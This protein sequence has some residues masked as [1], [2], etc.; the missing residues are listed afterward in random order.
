MH[1]ILG[2]FSL[3]MFA[4]IWWYRMKYLSEAAGEA[5]DAIGRVQSKIRREKMRKKSALAP[6][7]AID[8]PITA[9][10]TIMASIASEDS[11]LSPILE[12]GVR[13]Q[14]EKLETGGKLEEA[15]VYAKWASEQVAN[16]PSVI[17]VAGK[18]LSTKLNDDEKH[19]LIDMVMNAVPADKRHEA[20]P[21]RLKRL[22]VKLG[23]QVN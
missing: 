6:I 7:T 17:D 1:I 3:I 8:D 16:V 12:S 10:A 21:D 9:A 19:E 2:L 4:A 13:A 20:F 18:Y 23:L 11:V 15:L 22:R 5:A 14:L